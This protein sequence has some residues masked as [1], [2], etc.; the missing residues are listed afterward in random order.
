M[1]GYLACCRAG[2]FSTALL[3]GCAAA[4]AGAAGDCTGFSDIKDPRLTTARVGGTERASFVKGASD[5][6][7]CPAAESKCRDKAFLVP[8]DLVVA[9]ATEAG[10]TCVVYVGGKGAERAGWPATV[11]LL[12]DDP[13]PGRTEDWSGP[14]ISIEAEI[15]IK[16]GRFSVHG[17]A[18]YGALDPNRVKRGAVNVGAFDGDVAPTGSLL[19]FDVGTGATLPFDKGDDTDCKV[20]MRRLTPFL[21]VDD[22]D[23]CGGANVSFR[24]TY[25]RKP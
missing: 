2:I 3:L 7:G 17:D 4:R 23:M 21:L 8:G 9:G 24:G 1:P 15:T 5:A 11:R 13:A 19:A 6:E 20:S 14:W 16:P 22:N 12:R 10:F 25:R 18:T